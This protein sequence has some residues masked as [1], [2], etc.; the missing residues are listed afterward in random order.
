M[1]SDNRTIFT[2]TLKLIDHQEQVIRVV[3]TDD[4][5]LLSQFAK[6]GPQLPYSTRITHQRQVLNI[7]DV[8]LLRIPQMK[9]I[10]IVCLIVI[11]T[12]SGII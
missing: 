2:W 7:C 6:V 4:G 12:T 10:E 8:S 9:G 5:L 3:L 1:Y 11:W